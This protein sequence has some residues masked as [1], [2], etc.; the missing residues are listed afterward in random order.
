[1][2][3]I[4]WDSII[5]FVNGESPV[6]SMI[7]KNSDWEADGNRFVIRISGSGT[8]IFKQ[9]GLD[10]KI[11]EFV[12]DRFGIG[13]D[14]VFTNGGAAAY[15][16]E[17]TYFTP[18]PAPDA[19]PKTAK[20]ENIRK[21]TKKYTK[22]RQDRANIRVSGG[23]DGVVTKLCEEL[24]P[25]EDIVV[26]G[27][28]I[29]SRITE[30]KTDFN[31]ETKFRNNASG[32][33]LA[34]FDL[35]DRTGSVTVKFFVGKS[36]LGNGC[37]E[38]IKPG[39]A[40]R[41]WGRVCYDEYIHETVITAKEIAP[42]GYGVSVRADTYTGEKRIELNIHTR[43]G[44]MDG[45]CSA[46][47]C[48]RRAAAWG[49]RAVAV[50]DLNGTLSFPDAV[51]AARET[52]VKVIYGMEVRMADDSD[53]RTDR[54]EICG[55]VLLVRNRE[56]LRNLY[57]IVSDIGLNG[58]QPIKKS[59]VSRHRDGLLVG[60]AC[61]TGELYDAGFFDYLEI[62]PHFSREANERIVK[63]GEESG[64]PVAAVGG[65]RYL[66]PED[67]T[68][69]RI[70][71][72]AENFI[73]DDGNLPL[74]YM[75]TEEM[76]GEFRYL[77]EEKAR[78][79]VI[80]NTGFIADMVESVSPLPDADC[81]GAVDVDAVIGAVRAKAVSD[82]RPVRGGDGA[83]L[84]LPADYLPEAL[85]YARELLGGLDVYC[86]GEAVTPDETTAAAYVDSYFEG[87]NAEVRN[88]ERKR[89]A[90]YCAGVRSSFSVRNGKLVAVPKDVCIPVRRLDGGLAATH[91]DYDSV[92][93]LFPALELIEDTDLT[94]LDLLIRMTGIVPLTSEDGGYNEQTGYFRDNFPCEYHAVLFT[95]KKMYHNY[96]QACADSG[97][98]VYGV[99]LYKSG[100]E[101]FRTVNGGILPP[102][103]AVFGLS[104]A[105]ASNIA[106]ERE[107]GRFHS[108][109]EFQG[110]TGAS[111]A[112]VGLLKGMKVLSD[113]PETAQMS[114]F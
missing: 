32:K 13:L 57:A 110:R 85:C 75:T 14:L 64:R 28:V 101:D 20:P 25:D 77:G 95:V 59:L 76:L 87:R 83:V 102:L 17:E 74:H 80:T 48:I 91:F 90:G 60:A 18:P 100:A 30:M 78:E 84:H 37:R 67:A 99:D 109:Q 69:K 111:D 44:R 40:V 52:G 35:T 112:E 36:E 15:E 98:R 82:G 94:A 63:Y 114:L 104:A 3:S 103:C 19:V 106:A 62:R 23:I 11:R 92:S 46:A 12:R 65:V 70:V 2:K 16:R 24:E 61:E 49:H 54:P 42:G 71:D 34:V 50:T 10:V 6:C 31:G 108:V 113:L 55:A 81:Y 93:D 96:E 33:F 47:D 41:V 53:G 58:E 79:A 39:S 21:P 22:K 9:K 107:K 72:S 1:M 89:L 88:A 4:I 26:D 73:N 43:M 97:M 56:G 51:K 7:L 27:T 45:V 29:D 38:L 68:V 66:D 105:V 5:D 86:A 8:F